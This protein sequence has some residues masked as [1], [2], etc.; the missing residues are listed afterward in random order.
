MD[1]DISNWIKD[2]DNCVRTLQDKLYMIHINTGFAESTKEIDWDKKKI[3]TS[4]SY[5]KGETCEN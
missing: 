3:E 5:N 2:N 4:L 1:V